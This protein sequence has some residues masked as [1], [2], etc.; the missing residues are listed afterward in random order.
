MA[1]AEKQIVIA[2]SQGCEPEAWPA[3]K[4]SQYYQMCNG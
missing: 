2:V 1:P 3:A 4:Q